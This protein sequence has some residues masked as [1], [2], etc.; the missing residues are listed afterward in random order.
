MNPAAAIGADGIPSPANIRSPA[1]T[2]RRK[3]MVWP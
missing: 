1:R 2:N 3:I